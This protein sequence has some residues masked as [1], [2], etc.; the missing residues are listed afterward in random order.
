M[1]RESADNFRSAPCSI[2]EKYASSIAPHS[3]PPG[4]WPAQHVDIVRAEQKSL[5]VAE[6]GTMSLLVCLCGVRA[7]ERISRYIVCWLVS[8]VTANG[9]V[10]THTNNSRNHHNITLIPGTYFDRIMASSG[11]VQRTHTHTHFCFEWNARFFRRPL[12]L[13]LSSRIHSGCSI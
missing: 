9:L 4:D 10:A 7:R 2:G 3:T 8:C 11:F 1:Y 13:G 6:H 12:R 5:S